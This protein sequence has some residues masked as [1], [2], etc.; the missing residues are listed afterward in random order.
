MAFPRLMARAAGLM[1][2]LLVQKMASDL[3]AAVMA[4]HPEIIERLDG[5]AAATFAFEPT[6][7]DLRF[8]IQP[9]RRRIEVR[10]SGEPVEADARV[11]GPLHLLLLLAEGEADADALF[12]SRD[13]TVT[14]DMEALL[15]LRNVLDDCRID[16]PACMAG[17]A[18]PFGGLAEGVAR[19]VRRHVLG[20][21]GAAWN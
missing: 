3:F 4:A 5:H 13:L 8:L 7:M 18:G 1:P 16:I 11:A 19:Q 20:P 2:R 9:A 14:G 17:L 12:F 10:K 6:D 21:E 15:A